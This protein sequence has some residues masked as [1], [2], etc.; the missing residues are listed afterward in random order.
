MLLGET[1]AG[2][3]SAHSKSHG[4]VICSSGRTSHEGHSRMTVVEVGWGALVLNGRTAY[5]G[6]K[7]KG[8]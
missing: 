5:F 7:G 8:V 6:E 4:T 2:K 3:N 1:W